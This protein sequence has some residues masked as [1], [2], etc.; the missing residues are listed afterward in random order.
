MGWHPP[1]ALRRVPAPSRGAWGLRSGDAPVSIP[2]RGLWSERWALGG[3]WLGEMR[4]RHEERCV[5]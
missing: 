3:G 1:G 5:V 2:H 4:G